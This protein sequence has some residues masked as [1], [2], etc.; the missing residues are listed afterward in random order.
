MLY[1]YIRRQISS[2]SCRR[3]D[4]LQ[5]NAD[6][7]MYMFISHEQCVEETHNKRLPIKALTMLYSSKHTGLF[8]K[9]ANNSNCHSRRN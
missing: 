9:Y 6:I 1:V 7:I 8:G 3:E 4:G 5:V 2:I